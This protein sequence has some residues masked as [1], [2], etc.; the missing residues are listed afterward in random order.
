MNYPK[1]IPHH[2][3][4]KFGAAEA[5]LYSTNKSIRAFYHY[6]SPKRKQVLEMH[7]HTFYEINI[8]LEG[9]TAHYINDRM[10]VAPVGSVF[11]IP[12]DV[13]HGYYSEDSAVIFQLVLTDSFFS[14]YSSLLYSLNNYHFIFKIEPA[15]R[16]KTDINLSLLL[17]DDELKYIFPVLERLCQYDESPVSES[18]IAQEFL[19]LNLIAEIC[20]LS[21]SIIDKQEETSH[22]IHAIIKAMEYINLHYTENI[23]FHILAK[24]SNL[25]Y[26]TFFRTF[27]NI[28]RNTPIQYLS[29]C[30]IEKALDMIKKNKY[31]L[32]EIAHSCGFYDSS[33]FNKVFKG[34]MGKSPKEFKAK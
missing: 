12:P 13:L 24:N 25:S 19:V 17:S 6:L 11:V 1:K 7:A 10:I 2:K 18:F 23:D 34:I 31:S 5:L 32:T 30:R 22:N 14:A 21:N 33:H 16:R 20:I 15:I 4:S 3:T 29:K 26:P 8:V 27:K 9:S 28:S